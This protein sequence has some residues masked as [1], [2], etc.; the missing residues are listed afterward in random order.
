[1]T[2]DNK[3][4]PIS[5]SPNPITV[6]LPSGVIQFKGTYTVSWSSPC[7]ASS[8]SVWLAQDQASGDERISLQPLNDVK[9]SPF[10][11]V[12]NYFQPFDSGLAVVT[13]PE[14]YGFLQYY[15]FGPYDK[16][17]YVMYVY[18]KPD[19]A[20]TVAEKGPRATI[21]DLIVYPYGRY[22]FY[23][24]LWSQPSAGCNAWGYSDYFSISSVSGETSTVP[25]TNTIEPKESSVIP[26]VKPKSVAANT[27]ATLIR[28][29]TGRILLQVESKGEAWYVDG[30][31]Q[32]RFYLKD[33]STAYEALRKFGTGVTDTDLAKIPI[34][35]ESR[36]VIADTDGD[37]L[38]D[39]LEEAI[40]TDPA[41]AD[42]DSDGYPDGVELKSGNNPRGVGKLSSNIAFAS[43]LKGKIL[44]QVQGRGQ[45]WYVNPNDGKRY[46]MKD[47]NSAY[48][49]MKYLSLG[50]TNDN[51]HKIAVGEF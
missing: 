9:Y 50:I 37:G 36:A 18:T 28:R 20:I 31:T 32:Q 12:F 34:G 17:T 33:G 29:L 46:Y 2:D 8:Y 15:D 7:K 22:R 24:T 23:V 48:Q 19:A 44:L 41:R 43:K 27:D 26:I 42:T 11:K 35:I 38:D 10:T 49:I 1:M 25:Q 21:D 3:P 51:L 16:E 45:A 6:R 13:I 40:G 4:T 47:G 30:K 39:K 5:V 14:F